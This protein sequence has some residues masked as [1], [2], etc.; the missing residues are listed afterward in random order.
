MPECTVHH[1]CPFYGKNYN[2][3]SKWVERNSDFK[4][5]L[6]VHYIKILNMYTAKKQKEEKIKKEKRKR[7]KERE[8]KKRNK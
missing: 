2:Q 1:I 7:K 6:L 4:S 8:K 3:S 5:V